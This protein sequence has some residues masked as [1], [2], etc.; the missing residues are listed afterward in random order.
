M[1]RRS[2]EQLQTIGWAQLLVPF[3][4]LLLA[5]LPQTSRAMTIPTYYAYQLA[6]TEV[7]TSHFFAPCTEG[8]NYIFLSKIMLKLNFIQYKLQMF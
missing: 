8:Q 5:H 4:L 6:D 7:K 1:S 2:F 3:F